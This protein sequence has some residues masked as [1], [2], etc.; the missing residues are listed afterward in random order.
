MLTVGHASQGDGGRRSERSLPR[1]CPSQGA[2]RRD[3][4]AGACL[5][6]L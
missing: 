1:G 5:G 4:G 6:E 3:Y 2:L